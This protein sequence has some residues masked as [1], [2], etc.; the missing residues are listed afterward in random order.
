MRPRSDLCWECQKNNSAVFHS[1]NLT[2][3]QKAARVEKQVEHLRVVN[4]ERD[5]YREMVKNSK[6]I[7]GDA[8]LGNNAPCTRD[9]AMHYSFDFA[10]Q[11]HIPS[12]PE[13]PGPIYFLC[14]RKVG[15]FGIA[16]EAVP[17]QVNY[18]IDEGMSISKGSNAVISYMHDFFDNFGLGESSV[19]LHCDNCSGQNKNRFMMWYLSWRTLHRL[20]TDI[21]I[22][23]L[24]VGHTKFAPDWGFGLIKKRFRRCMCS[25]LQDVANVISSST[26]S[27]M[28]IPRSVGTEGGE[29]LVPVFDWQAFLG[30]YFRPLAGIKAM[31]HMRFSSDHPGVA[32]IKQFADSAE[33]P[34]NI[35]LD[36][37]LRP[38]R[39][40]PS[41][42]PPPG[43][44]EQ[45]MK[46]LYTTIRE[47]CTEDTRNIVC[48]PPQTEL[49]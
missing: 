36:P 13:Q 3:V 31:H 5:C 12:N 6:D 19:H 4:L 24:V 39:E 15:L 27:G 14:P 28:N 9:F 32:F 1:A 26:T 44:S 23:F 41:P 35:L 30:P 33:T 43:L 40:L 49:A 45:R 29:T 42:L 18:I 34:V 37:T 16:C 8:K 10:Q 20:H 47:F 38:P 2:D 17:S 25:S 11:V 21:T 48:P 7:I 46:Y 22:N